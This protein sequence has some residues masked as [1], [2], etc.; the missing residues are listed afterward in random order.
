MIKK[1][2]FRNKMGIGIVTLSLI[3]LITF[4]INVWAQTSR[5]DVFVYVNTM[6]KASVL[7]KDLQ[8]AIP[9]AQIR[10]FSR[11]T[12]F[13]KAVA[14]ESPE[15]VIARK[16]LVQKVNMTPGL[17]G[18]L[19]GQQ[20]EVYVLLTVDKAVNV[21][22]LDG[23]SVGAVDEF[24]RRQT[25]SFVTEALGVKPT[26]KRTVKVEDLLALLQFSAADAIF[27]PRRFTPVLQKSSQ[28]KL[29]ET[30]VP[31]ASMPL[32]AVG[33]ASDAVKTHILPQIKNL[34]GEINQKIGV[35]SWQ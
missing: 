1:N 30:T 5:S 12:D 32:P 9:G 21:A 14:E 4:S 27:L 16:N 33:F 8:S 29:I 13:Q 22:S 19:N 26:V 3:A 6:V 31:N 17:Q 23:N 34:S 20:S 25:S 18:I 15:V 24:G 11:N 28:L 7:Q 2:L 10:V 35:D